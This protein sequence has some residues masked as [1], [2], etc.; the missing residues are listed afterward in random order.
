MKMLFCLLFTVHLSF[1][2]FGQA[3]PGAYKWT[4]TL[5]VVDDSDNPIEDAQTSIAFND[6]P[7]SN[8]PADFFHSSDWAKA[9]EMWWGS[10]VFVG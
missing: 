8:L 3:R 5:K 1:H 2:A 7:E 4:I 10:G 6:P 9:V